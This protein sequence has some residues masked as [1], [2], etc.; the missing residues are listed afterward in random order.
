MGYSRF[1]INIIKDEINELIVEDYLKQYMEYKGF[2]LSESSDD[3]KRVVIKNNP[4]S[5]WITVYD[6][7]LSFEE[8]DTLTSNISK[9]FKT[10]CMYIAYF[11]SDDMFIHLFYDNQEDLKYF[12]CSFDTVMDNISNEDYKDI[13]WD[14][15]SKN[16]A[17]LKKILNNKNT[18][19]DDLI[20]TLEKEIGICGNDINVPI[21][22]IDNN[23]NKTLYFRSAYGD[24]PF[25]SDGDTKIEYY[26]YGQPELNSENTYSFINRG[27][28]S[29][30]AIIDITCRGVK[31]I[32]IDEISI[33]RAKNT[34]QQI[35]FENN[36]IKMRSITEKVANIDN[37][38]I[39]AIFP[40]FVFPEGVNKNSNV[41]KG[42]KL[43]IAELNHMIVVKFKPKGFYDSDISDL[44]VTM[45]P[46]SNINGYATT[47]LWSL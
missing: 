15:I 7:S 44:R 3:C 32:E 22:N 26:I 10:Y 4:D 12:G 19:T 21:N 14:P 29:K 17:G 33:L 41:L 39:R 40:V 45:Q 30:G 46:I 27:G 34:K 16:S 23:N 5:K 28:I 38:Y 24:K 43:Q 11:D 35:D 6:D 20:I 37:V 25:I 8:A 47:P 9:T 2:V 31:E 18:T 1:N 13:I 36:I 42:S